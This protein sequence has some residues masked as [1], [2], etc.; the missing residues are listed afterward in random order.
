MGPAGVRRDIVVS[1]NG[2]IARALEMPDV[3]EKMA[4]VGSEAAPSTPEDLSKR[5]VEWMERF[6]QI[7]KQAGI[8][9]Q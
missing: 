1:L 3:R 7:A 5:Y 2:A 9:P 6:G 8:K 4:T